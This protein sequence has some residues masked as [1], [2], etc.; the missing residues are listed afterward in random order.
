MN[1]LKNKNNHFIRQSILINYLQVKS[2]NKIKTKIN[3]KNKTKNHM[4]KYNPLFFLLLFFAQQ[5]ILSSN[6]SIEN[7]NTDSHIASLLLM[8]GGLITY[9]ISTAMYGSSAPI[10]TIS[11]LPLLCA[12]IVINNSDNSIKPACIT[13]LMTYG[14][15]CITA[16]LDTHDNTLHLM[17]N[18]PMT[19]L[20]KKPSEIPYR[21]IAA[22]MACLAGACILRTSDT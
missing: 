2:Y 13:G 4:K 14:A 22:S 1:F 9:G 11:S 8:G 16:E 18:I 5:Q 3:F 20:Y 10:S 6:T 17:K 19:Y 15:L 12:G 7:A 21:T